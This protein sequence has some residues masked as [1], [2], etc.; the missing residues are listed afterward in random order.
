[1]LIFI[2]YIRTF[3]KVLSS[4]GTPSQIAGGFVLGMALGLIPFN[5]IYS[6][7]LWGALFMIN[8]SISAGFLG[9]MVFFGMTP[10]LDYVSHWVGHSLLTLPALTGIWT[11]MYNVPI[12]PLTHFNNTVVLGSA[13]LVLA[14]S[15]PLYFLSKKGV[16]VYRKRLHKRVKKSKLFKSLKA[17]S[18]VKW[19]VKLE[20]VTK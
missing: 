14:L 5:M 9:W 6:M 3:I 1:M 16:L 8:I 4:D 19:I 18:I 2:K 12:M 20:K 7:I 13:G 17:M 10:L 11:W 15:I